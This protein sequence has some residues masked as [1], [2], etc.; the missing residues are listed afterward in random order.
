MSWNRAPLAKD[1]GIGIAEVIQNS[2]AYKKHRKAAL[3]ATN[4]L[5]W[6]YRWLAAGFSPTPDRVSADPLPSNIKRCVTPQEFGCGVDVY[7]G[8]PS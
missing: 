3:A 5:P 2:G 4:I 8:K 1:V 6:F 7:I